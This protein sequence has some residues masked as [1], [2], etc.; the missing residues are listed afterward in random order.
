[1]EEKVLPYKR[2]ILYVFLS[3]SLFFVPLIMISEY[4]GLYL[5]DPEDDRT[6][7]FVLCLG[8]ISLLLA[9]R[10]LKPIYFKKRV[11][12]WSEEGNACWRYCLTGTLV[13]ALVSSLLDHLYIP[14][15]L[16]LLLE[17]AIVAGV[18]MYFYVRYQSKFSKRF[19][20]LVDSIRQKSDGNG[21]SNEPHDQGS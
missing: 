9:L 5:G 1:M 17:V 4:L 8:F 3:S 11:G 10:L 19:I 20:E 13:V 18:A 16:T 7:I 6:N 12:D 14:E 2:T 15:L 21:S